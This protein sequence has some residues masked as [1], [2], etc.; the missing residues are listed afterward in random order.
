[1]S[2]QVRQNNTSD[3]IGSD[4]QL[5]YALLQTHFTEYNNVLRGNPGEGRTYGHAT[6]LFRSFD[7]VSTPVYLTNGLELIQDGR[8]LKSSINWLTEDPTSSQPP[9]EKSDTVNGVYTLVESGNTFEVKHDFATK[10]QT[11]YINGKRAVFLPKITFNYTRQV[12]VEAGPNTALIK[13][14]A[15]LAKAQEA[16]GVTRRTLTEKTA[17]A[18][19]LNTALAS[20]NQQKATAERKVANATTALENIRQ[21][22][23]VKLQEASAAQK[24]RIA[25]ANQKLE[26]ATARLATANT[27]LS[28]AMAARAA[29]AAEVKSTQDVIVELTKKLAPADKVEAAVE[30]VKETFTVDLTAKAEPKVSE[31]TPAVV[32]KTEEAAKEQNFTFVNA[33]AP[34][35]TVKSN[36]LPKDVTEAVVVDQAPKVV[37]RGTSAGKPSSSQS[38][39]GKVFLPETGDV[40][41]ALGLV[42]VGLLAL[43][44]VAFKRRHQAG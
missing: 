26:A 40:A 33:T 4:R 16:L 42:G 6:A 44:A 11:L 37:V 36:K 25:R 38:R 9:I 34:M 27:K 32:T 39:S 13:A 5:A 19:S 18:D 12:P 2:Y 21:E 30:A 14:Q 31:A 28:D 22:N 3:R 10:V 1:M 24:E 17:Q 7:G 8:R 20:L 41:S 29:K 23:A 15:D 43:S 35:A